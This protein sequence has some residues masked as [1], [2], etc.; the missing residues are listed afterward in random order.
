MLVHVLIS[1]DRRTFIS[2]FFKTPKKKKAAVQVK[3][4]TASRAAGSGPAASAAAA[5]VTEPTTPEPT[6]DLESAWLD[7]DD[8]DAEIS[9]ALASAQNL[10]ASDEL[11]T[12]DVEDAK[13]VHDEEVVR[14]VKAEAIALGRQLNITMTSS[15]E[16]T[17]LGLFPK[18]SFRARSW[19][20]FF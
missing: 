6:D 17:A 11:V 16:R 14:S 5:A 2:F 13:A 3:K 15:E 4:S 20:W 1:T 19:F 7:E 18:V 10:D 8:A 12:D 9:A